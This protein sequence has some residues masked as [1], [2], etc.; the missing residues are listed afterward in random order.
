MAD[1]YD[2]KRLGLTEITAATGTINT[3]DKILVVDPTTL[4][5][6]LELVSNLPA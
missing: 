6:R 5:P 1:Q 4:V 3:T 2:L